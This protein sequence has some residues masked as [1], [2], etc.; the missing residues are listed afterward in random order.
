MRYGKG[1]IFG[2]FKLERMVSDGGGMAGVYEARAVEN[3]YAEGG[4]KVALKIARWGDEYEDIYEKLL[5]KETELL[6]ELRHPGI[7]RIMPIQQGVHK[8]WY[9][10]ARV[11]ANDVPWYFA[12]ELLEGGSMA[13]V[14]GNNKFS[15]P[16]RVEL[17][18]QLAS[19]IDYL[20]IREVAHRDLKPENILF[21][22][23]P[24]RKTVP[25][26]VLIDF[27]LV[28]KRQLQEEE[29]GGIMAATVAYAP[30][31]WVRRLRNTG[32]Q[33]SEI[34]EDK[35]AFDVWALGVIAYEL[36][37]GK[38]PFG[39]PDTQQ[40]TVLEEQIKTKEPATMNSDVP[41][42]VQNLVLGMLEKDPRQRISIEDVLERLET[43]IEYISPRI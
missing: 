10:R 37:N 9:A 23:T 31:E 20:H 42:G 12:M 43:Q 5:K 17:I 41:Q 36:L 35:L 40:R 30:P 14:I 32:K 25:T 21:R 28:E 26:P 24:D 11:S 22:H 34:F 1:T 27:G 39:R 18:Y 8:R 7:V 2:P 3:T 19:I 16:W 33:T 38:H 4:A 15:L 13:N 29:E 6:R